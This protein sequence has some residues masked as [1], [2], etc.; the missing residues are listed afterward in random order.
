MRCLALLLAV[1]CA[2]CAETS[3]PAAVPYAPAPRRSGAW[4]QF[5]EQAWNVAHAS[6]LA[7]ARGADGWELVAMY[8][9]VLC[10]KR[11]TPSSLDVREYRPQAAPPGAPSSQPYVPVVRDPGF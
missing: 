11:A 10:F 5:C 2:G 4:Q 1:V 7:G 3:P 6:S 9:G 8:N